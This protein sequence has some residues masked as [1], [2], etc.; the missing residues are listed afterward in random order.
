MRSAASVVATLIFSSENMEVAVELLAQGAQ[1]VFDLFGL[2]REDGDGGLEIVGRLGLT[3]LSI[4][5][6]PCSSKSSQ[7]A[8]RN[9]SWSLWRE[10]FGRPFAA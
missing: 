4:T 1:R 2:F 7:N 10:P 9:H 3:T 6:A 5:E 8:A